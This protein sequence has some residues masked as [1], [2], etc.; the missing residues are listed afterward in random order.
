MKTKLMAMQDASDIVNK[1]VAGAAAVGWIPGSTFI[2]SPGD[3]AMISQVAS[4]FNVTSYAVEEVAGAVLAETTGRFVSDFLLSLIPIAGWIVKAGVAAG[5]TKALGEATIHY[6]WARSPLWHEVK[7]LN[8]LSGKSLDLSGWGTA[9]GSAVQVWEYGGGSN[10]RWSF[11]YGREGSLQVVSMH[12]PRVLDVPGSVD[13]N[14]PLQVWDYWAGYNQNFRIHRHD[15]NGHRIEC[16]Q[17]GH[18]LTAE[19]GDNGARVRAL[20]GQD[21]PASQWEIWPA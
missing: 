2:L 17:S 11:L 9:N 4:C 20:W 3:L 5:I 12:C 6:M 8:R 18:I 1:Y 14:H 7:L 21:G 19:S 16:H 13:S 10:Q 15:S